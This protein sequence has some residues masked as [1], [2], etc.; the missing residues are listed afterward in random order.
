MVMVRCL[1]LSPIDPELMYKKIQ[2]QGEQ[3]SKEL[4]NQVATLKQMRVVQDILFQ[5]VKG[6]CKSG[7]AKGQ[8]YANGDYKLGEGLLMALLTSK[9]YVVVCNIIEG[10]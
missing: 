6:N 5:S 3:G 1:L 7:C 2:D 4:C 9:C 10:R 8:S